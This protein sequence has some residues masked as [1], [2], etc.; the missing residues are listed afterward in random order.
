M[1]RLHQARVF[2]AA[3]MTPSFVGATEAPL[4][5]CYERAYDAVHLAAHK[6]Q[7]VTRA[8]LLVKTTHMPRE[9]PWRDIIADACEFG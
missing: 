3:L 9:E 2:I 8:T 1:R 5:G 4:A 6:K 7:L